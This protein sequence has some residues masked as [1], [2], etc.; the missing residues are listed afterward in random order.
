MEVDVEN[1]YALCAAVDAMLG[2]NRRVVQVTIA[3]HVLTTSMVTGRAAKRE[4]GTRATQQCIHA[5]QCRVGTGTDRGPRTRVDGGTGV[6]RKE[7]KLA[8]DEFGQL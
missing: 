7:A 3:A 1:G 5:G 2:R 4:C 8:I 6:H